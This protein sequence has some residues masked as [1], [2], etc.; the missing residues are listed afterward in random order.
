MHCDADQP[1][2]LTMVVFYMEKWNNPTASRPV[3]VLTPSIDCVYDTPRVKWA[4]SDRF[5]CWQ[6]KCSVSLASTMACGQ[7]PLNYREMAALMSSAMT[8]L[9]KVSDTTYGLLRVTA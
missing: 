7:A 5:C 6:E 8:F 3:M 9:S 4:S 2:L 1:S